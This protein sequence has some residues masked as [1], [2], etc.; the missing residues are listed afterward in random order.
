[1]K[2]SARPGQVAILLGFLGFLI[3]PTIISLVRPDAGKELAAFELRTLSD[4][5]GP[6]TNRDAIATF[7]RRLDAWINDRFPLRSH[8]VLLNSFISANWLKTSPSSSVAL[9][10]D[11]FLFYRSE[12]ALDQSRGLLLFQPDELDRLIDLFETRRKWLAALGI[13]LLLV[14]VPNKE[15]VYRDRLPRWASEV[16]STTQRQQ[17]TARIKQ[18]ALSLNVLDLTDG[19]IAAKPSRQTY[20]RNDT[21]WTE[22]AAFEDGYLPILDGVKKLLPRFEL[23]NKNDWEA[24]E[25]VRKGA[26]LDLARM[27]GLAAVTTEVETVMRLKREKR[28]SSFQVEKLGATAVEVMKG[29]FPGSPK[30]VWFRDSFTAAFLEPI[31]EVFSETVF[32]PREAL[33]FSKSIIEHRKPDVVVYQF[34]ERFLARGIPVE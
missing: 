10:K 30:A 6:P 23:P 24:I 5:P 32:V 20:L 4:F 14:I 21:H 33:T 16:T 26:R 19:L 28:F 8:L 25:I 12:N 2:S 1:M 34:A 18:R 22:E 15:T 11:G 27:A 3:A 7:P 29:G 31:G 13:P 9:G 17:F